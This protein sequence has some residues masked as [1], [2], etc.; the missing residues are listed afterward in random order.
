[1]SKQQQ[2]R[3]VKIVAQILEGTKTLKEIGEKF[4]VTKQRV[5]QIAQTFGINRWE[6]K[7]VKREKLVKVMERGLE[8][9]K[10]IDELAK[11][12]S[13][14]PSQMRSM[15]RYE[16]GKNY[17]T[18]SRKRRDGII[19]EKFVSGKTA[20]KI[21]DK[22]GKS[23]DIPRRVT[24]T[25]WIY[26]I[27]TKNSV[28]RYPNIGNRREG[29]CF[30]NKQALKLIKSKYE[31]HNWSFEDIAAEL[32]KRGFRTPQNVLFTAPQ[33]NRYYRINQK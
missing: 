11:K 31:N 7:K 32:N 20:Q 18:E 2:V 17:T 3:N 25:N 21:V 33:V 19:V 14:T 30:V 9:N 12:N 26:S 24:T 27:N 6:Q 23:L 13:L 28:K 4:G 1:M 15:Y 8:A 5:R 22:V 10:T 16:S 29:G